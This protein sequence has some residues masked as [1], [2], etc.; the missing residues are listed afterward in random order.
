MK[1]KAEVLQ[2]VKQFA[3]EIGAPESIICDMAGEQ[4]SPA[5]K[6]FCQEIGAT[7]KFLEEGTPWANKAELHIGLTKEAVRKD[8]KESDCPLAFGTAALS[9]E[10]E[11]IISRRKTV[12]PCMG[13]MRTRR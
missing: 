5:L 7:M 9:E 10:R 6:R 1:S 2:A 13:Q 8:V 4:T 12:S 11:L 3:K